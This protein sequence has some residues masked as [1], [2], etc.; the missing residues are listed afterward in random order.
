MLLTCQKY[1]F[2]RKFY[3]WLELF[4]KYTPILRI[5]ICMQQYLWQENNYVLNIKYRPHQSVVVTAIPFVLLTNEEVTAET[6][7]IYSRFINLCDMI[8]LRFLWD[9]ETQ[10]M[11]FCLINTNLPTGTTRLLHVC[12]MCR[13]WCLLFCCTEVLKINSYKTRNKHKHSHQ[14]LLVNLDSVIEVQSPACEP[15]AK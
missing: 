13:E 2:Q 5:T 1:T 14:H 10:P 3:N 7:L 12:G 8:E 6:L 15:Q 9:T 4:L 11:K